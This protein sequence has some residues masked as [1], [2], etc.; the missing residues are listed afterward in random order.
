M[1][2]FFTNFSRAGTFCLDGGHA[3]LLNSN[4]TFGDFGLRS[5]GSR[6]LVVPDLSGV[7][8]SLDT[9]GSALLLTQKSNIQ[10][11][12]INKLSQSGSF[13]SSY[14]SGSGSRYAA[15]IKDSGYLI[16]ALSNDLLSPS[17]TNTS[18]FI[19]G[20]FKGQDV[21]SGSV[22][23]LPIASGSTFTKGVVTIIPQNIS[24]SSGS[25][26]GDFIKSYQYI[27]EYI[28]TDPSGNFSTMSASAKGKVG[29]ML[30]VLIS[31]VTQVVVNAAGASLIQEFG[32]LITS[33]SHDFSY[34]GAGVNFLALPVNQ[35]GIGATNLNMR[36]YQE[37]NGRVYYTAGDETGDFYAGS[38]FIIRQQ[39]GTIEGRTFTKAISAQITPINLAL[40]TYS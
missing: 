13:A 21:S 27:K 20:L 12:M 8:A 5:S 28:V 34:A 25:L 30:D 16:N 17:A 33:T 19:Q 24:N 15:T 6:L 23:T 4:T 40:E 26:T 2:S 11:Y 14:V 32:S 3:S 9:S 29:Q 10:T 1:V 31:T 39:T 7:S 36:V 22:Y 38:D 37:A 18:Q 35:G